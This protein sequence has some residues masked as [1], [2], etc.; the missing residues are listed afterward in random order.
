[1]VDSTPFA[2]FDGLRPCC[3]CLLSHSASGS[4]ASFNFV[5]NL[6]EASVNVFEQQA[7]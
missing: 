4:W 5:S 2:T 3:L 6:Y 7:E 1:M